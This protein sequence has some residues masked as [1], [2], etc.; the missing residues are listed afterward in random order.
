MV[1]LGLEG[2]A[3]I[4]VRLDARADLDCLGEICD[5]PIAVALGLVGDAA[6]DISGAVPRVYLDRL[7]I[8]RNGSVVL[9]LG[10]VEMPRFKQALACRGLISIALV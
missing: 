7:G 10:L 8:V 5:R 6:I 2:I 1:A 9:A 3:A 4:F